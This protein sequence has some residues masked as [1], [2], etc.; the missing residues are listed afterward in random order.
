ML[1]I[2]LSQIQKSM[3]ILK[4]SIF[5]NTHIH[6]CSWCIYLPSCMMTSYKILMFICLMKHMLELMW[7]ISKKTFVWLVYWNSSFCKALEKHVHEDQSFSNRCIDRENC[8]N[9]MIDIGHKKMFASFWSFLQK[10]FFSTGC[11]ILK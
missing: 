9:H 5:T 10:R 2:S 1:T 4:V 7:K 8:Q 6:Y 3:E 11:V